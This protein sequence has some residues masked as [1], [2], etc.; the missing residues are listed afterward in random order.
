[1]NPMIAALQKS[2]SMPMAPGKDPEES[3][4]GEMGQGGMQKYWAMI[5]DMNTKLDKLLT[6]MGGNTPDMKEKESNSNGN[7]Y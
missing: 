7:G 4:P 2:R 6:L 3:G 5:E 1:M